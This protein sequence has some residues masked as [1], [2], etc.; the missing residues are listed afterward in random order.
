VQDLS[1]SNRILLISSDEEE[2]QLIRRFLQQQEPSKWDLTRSINLPAIQEHLIASGSTPLFSAIIVDLTEAEKERLEFLRRLTVRLFHLN[3]IVILPEQGA[4][5]A[6]TSSHSGAQ[7]FLPK[8]GYGSDDLLNVLHMSIGRTQQ[9]QQWDEL[10]Q[11]ANM[12]HW[13]Y[14]LEEKVLKV[15]PYLMK[16]YGRDP[17]K[18]WYAYQD[19]D[20]DNWPRRVLDKMVPES[21]EKGRSEAELEIVDNEGATRTIRLESRLQVQ[22][23]G[24]RRLIGLLHDLSRLRAAELQVAQSKELERRSEQLKERFIASV[25][26]EMRTPMNAIVGLAHLLEESGLDSDQRKMVDDLLE[27]AN[28]LEHIV[29][30]LLELSAIQQGQIRLEEKAFDLSE[31][32]NYVER[33]HQIKA[34]EKGLMLKVSICKEVPLSIVGDK[35]RLSQILFNVIGNAI[36]YTQQ[37]KV[38]LSVQTEQQGEESWLCFHVEDTGVGIPEVYQPYLFKPFS[39]IPQEEMPSGTG[40]GLAIVKRLVE[41]Q[42]GAVTLSSTEGQGTKVSLRVPMVLPPQQN[43]TRE[44]ITDKTTKPPRRFRF[45]VAEDHPLNRMVLVNFLQKWYPTAEVVAVGDGAQ[46]LEVFRR[47]SLFDLLILD[48]QM[49]KV[50]GAEVLQTLR[51]DKHPDK[52]TTS[53]MFLTAH[54]G[55][56]VLAE[57]E[58]EGVQGVLYKPIDP[59]TLRKK[60]QQIIKSP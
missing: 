35:G 44:Q 51:Q 34:K 43:F 32:L 25:S 56:Q 23:G 18:N 39:R 26:H 20:P 6:A 7:G 36:K 59:V 37:G 1:P 22:G 58:R 53:V 33:I 12:G 52:R 46:A 48:L 41:L 19:L 17:D 14:D 24:N 54:T 50:D 8:G 2:Y 13:E 21:L 29:Q 5:L 42:G 40:L 55:Q 60:V 10:N 30:D 31:L 4:E 15:S 28:M 57:V 27:S 49:P 11:L 16:K 45:L 9:N 3:A 47:E 38:C